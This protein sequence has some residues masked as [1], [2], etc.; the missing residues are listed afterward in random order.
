MV[1]VIGIDRRRAVIELANR[2]DEIDR[3]LREIAGELLEVQPMRPGALTLHQYRCGKGCAGCPH[4]RWLQ[5]SQARSPDK[6]MRRKLV[7]H[8]TTHPL[9]RIRRT[10]VFKDT[11]YLVRR[12]VTE[13]Q[14]LA[15]QRELI[16]THVA[17]ARRSL[18][19]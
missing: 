11:A 12:L 14:K 15:R 16:L 4:P 3:R 10:G 7:G 5:W 9:H 19:Y 2:L 6:E 17:A 1:E 18:R 13:A 8:P